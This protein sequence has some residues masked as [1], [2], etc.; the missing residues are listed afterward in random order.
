LRIWIN[1]VKPKPTFEPE[2]AMCFENLLDQWRERLALFL[3]MPLEE[4]GQV[5]GG[6]KRVTGSIDIGL[7]QSLNRKGEVKDM[8]AGYGQIIV[9]ECHHI[10]AK[11][12][13]LMSEL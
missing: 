1:I 7:I 11:H 9:D 3:G 10:P 8:V 5:S 2:P 12:K 6:K 13:S 4:I